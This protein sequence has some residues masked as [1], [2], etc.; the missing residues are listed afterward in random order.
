MDT[1]GLES[2]RLSNSQLGA[3]KGATSP[4]FAPRVPTCIVDWIR[5][6]LR[7]SDGLDNCG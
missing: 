4:S 2:H 1:A 5:A 6:I 7:V 3:R